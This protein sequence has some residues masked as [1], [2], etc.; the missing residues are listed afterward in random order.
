MPSH[1]CE[2][3]PLAPP[4]TP[5][6]GF[7][8][9]SRRKSR[10]ERQDESRGLASEFLQGAGFL[11]VLVIRATRNAVVPHRLVVALLNLLNLL[12]VR[13]RDGQPR[14]QRQ[15]FAV[16]GHLVLELLRAPY[17][18]A[19]GKVLKFL[20]HGFVHGDV[21]EAQP[22]KLP[23]QIV[24]LRRGVDA[25]LVAELQ[26][27][28]HVFQ[29]EE[30]PAVKVR[31]LPRPHLMEREQRAVDELQM[32]LKLRRGEVEPQDDQFL[33][34]RGRGRRLLPIPVRISKLLACPIA[35][36]NSLTPELHHAIHQ[37][38][39]AGGVS[40]KV[41]E[42][43]AVR[44]RGDNAQVDRTDSEQVVKRKQILGLSAD[45]DLVVELALRHAI[46]EGH[47]DVV[48]VRWLDVLQ[49]LFAT[50]ARW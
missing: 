30:A 44:V 1:P 43:W 17:V 47:E 50:V 5:T 31:P 24:D 39:A 34:I 46:D 45:G 26:G 27:G 36:Q 8:A 38:E 35:V 28:A 20:H 2:A 22:F 37:L 29:R 11:D 15:N 19:L 25:N 6:T 49:R 33:E 9:A 42:V 32:E 4:K 14:G 13:V 23:N 16:D 41:P 10:Q 3:K 40:E 21:V 48:G 7:A 12:R 18:K